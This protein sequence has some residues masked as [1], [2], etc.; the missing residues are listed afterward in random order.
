VFLAFLIVFITVW[1]IA[2]RFSFSGGKS[3]YQITNTSITGIIR[4]TPLKLL[5]NTTI[6]M[7]VCTFEDLPESAKESFSPQF[8]DFLL[9]KTEAFFMAKVYY[10]YGIDLFEVSED[11]VKIDDNF[12]IISLPEPKLLRSSVDLNSIKDYTK[13]TILR[14]LWDTAAGREIMNELK[15]AFQ[16]KAAEF[17]EENGVKPTKAV[18]IKNIESFIHR[19][20]A[21]QTGKKVIFK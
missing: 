3:A 5:T 2:S 1:S 7:V 20:I 21:N 10:D 4:E 14:H 19:V 15:K 12:I 6:T 18:I 17:A 9:G 16:Q 11:S 13:T 8:R